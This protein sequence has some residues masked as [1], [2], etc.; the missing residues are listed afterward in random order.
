MPK[1]K[2]G[3]GSVYEKRGWQYIAYYV[4]GKQVVEA[5]GTKDRVKARKLLQSK[6]GKVAD[7]RY[8]GPAAERTKWEELAQLVLDDYRINGKK[9]LRDVK[10]RLTKH[11]SPFFKGKRARDISSADVQAFVGRRLAAKASHGEINREL[12]LL[13]RAFNLGLQAEIVA[14]KPAI[15]MLKEPAA[16]PGFFEQAEYEQLL[17]K[18]PDYLRPPITFAF[19][20]GWRMHSEILPLTWDQVDLDEGTVRLWAG[21]TKNREGRL[22]ALPSELRGLL[23]RL[24][25]E[26][27]SLW[28]DC[29]RVF[30]RRGQPIKIFRDAWKSACKN[31]GLEGR[32]PHDFRRTAARNMVRAGIPERVVM[33]LLGHKTR[34]M[35]DRYNIVSEG[36][37]RDAA[38]RMEIAMGSRTTTISTTRRPGHPETPKLTH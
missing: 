10:H 23:E 36:D 5:A 12:T 18:L 28:P 15:R 3:N 11:V 35:L 9:T 13:K 20:T 22:V 14:R 2:R 25:A 27:T 8:V 24:W 1:Y 37:L 4:D 26:H 30:Q 19:W 29:R 16:R 6:L 31:A 21:S 7:G 17:A 38:K 32:I 33:Q 34:S